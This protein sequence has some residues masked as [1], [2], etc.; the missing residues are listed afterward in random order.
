MLVPTYIMGCFQ[1]IEDALFCPFCGKKQEEFRFQTKSG[2]Y[3]MMT[4]TIEEIKG[5]I[6]RPLKLE[7]HSTCNDCGEWIS[8]NLDLMRMKRS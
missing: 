4:W 3:L 2:R 8:I 1:I 5:D 7:I 6:P